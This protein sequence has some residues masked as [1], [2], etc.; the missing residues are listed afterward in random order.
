MWNIRVKHANCNCRSRLIKMRD[1]KTEMWIKF[2][3]IPMTDGLD[4]QPIHNSN[5]MFRKRP[6]H[7]RFVNQRRFGL[8]CGLDL[9]YVSKVGLKGQ[10]LCKKNGI[11]TVCKK[12]RISQI[13]LRFAEVLTEWL[14]YYPSWKDS[15]AK[16]HN[17]RFSK[18]RNIIYQFLPTTLFQ[19]AQ[20]VLDARKC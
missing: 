15:A 17:T 18:N 7:H 1:S 11:S 6:I 20:I 14:I 13:W 12:S 9:V 2:T 19:I 3:Y 4:N 16:N 5:R 8:I 10:S